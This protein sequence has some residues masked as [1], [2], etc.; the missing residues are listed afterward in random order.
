M[1]HLYELIQ[2]RVA[3][4]R[5][6]GYPAEGYPAIGEILDYA[7]L[8]E[9]RGLRLLRAAQLRALETYW[10]LR[11]VEGTPH[12]FD[13]YQR[14]YT[15][16]LDLLGAL[17]MARDEIKDYVLNEGMEELWEHVRAG[18][19]FVKRHKLES[20]HETVSLDYPSYI[21]ALAMGA[22]K[23]MLIGTIV[24]T[25]F[26]MA[27]E[28]PDGP[29]VQNAL[30][31]APGLTILE[32]LREL[33]EVDYAKILPPRLYKP[34]ETTYKLIFTRDGEKDLPVIRGSR[35]NLVVTN[36]EKIRIQKR[37]RRHHTWTQL[38]YEHRQEQAE[39]EANLRLQAIA[40]LPN[41]GVFSDEAHHTYGREIGKSLKR[42]RQTVDYLHHN[43]DLLCVVNTT[44]TPYYERQP[45][46]DVVIWYGLSEG[47]RDNIL[48]AV[49]GSIYAYDFDPQH[50]DQ[51]VAEVVHDFLQQYGAVTLPNG[52]PARLAMYF[53]QTRDLRELRPVVERTLIE[54]GYPTDIV[55]RNTSNST[56][57][58]IDAFNRL[59]D[60]GS[61]H[62][63]I[64]LVNK[65]TEGWNCPSLFA[66]ALARK[67]RTSQNFV[68]Q[69]STRCLRQVPGN[70]HRARI[71][72]SMDNRGAL[73]RQ[74]QETYGETI[75]DLD[76]TSQNTQ[77]LKVVVRKVKVPPLVVRQTV[78]RV[79]PVE[80]GASG[81]LA[82]T[83]PEVEAGT[84]LVRQIYT[85]AERP[86]Q[87]SVMREVGE[88]EGEAA[89]GGR[90]LYSVATELAAVYRVKAW[91]VYRELR[92]LYSDGG[93]VPEAHLAALA[94]QIED[95][96]RR[97]RVIEEEVEVS[98]ALVR[99]EG[100]TQEERDGQVVYTAEIAYQKG[101]E[102]L[103][104]SWKEMAA[105][106]G[107]EFGFHYDPYCF[108]S[109]PER[110]FYVRMLEA[111]HL[112]EDQVEDIYFTG[113]LTDPQKTDFYVEYKGVDGRWHRYSPDFVIRRR[114]GRCY[115]VEI[116][117]ERERSHLVD[118]ER[119]RKAMAVQK[120]V[121]LNPETLRYEMI[122]TPA[123]SVAY[124]QLGPAIRFIGGE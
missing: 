89:V 10:Y 83:R 14:T 96:T 69:A 82:L 13:L 87:A 47:I 111:I 91:T 103:L 56:E 77:T 28:Y 72:L 115:I 11:L 33:A 15:R 79:V 80:D 22:G 102:H 5:E 20:V 58:E 114:D 108:D 116:K 30:V 46:R 37:V 88:Q 76:R 29:F 55:L 119:G 26:A 27:I 94:A 110:D 50:A 39:A 105:Q 31:F 23:T 17:G 32:S 44:G 92:R 19:G 123:D 109:S 117:A 66:C 35:Y 45:L 71:Y 65:G 70:T 98:L 38:E 16:P 12:I 43:T 3:E 113:A 118:G 59:N 67:L 4:W 2:Q 100:F 81:E 41:L 40:S 63:V 68:L 93:E 106:D 78:K 57:A 62:R 53:P 21:L 51:F 9:G 64:L 60:P 52:A 75:R 104:L 112:N 61:R 121:G 99:P 97:Y 34:F 36:T 48:K 25:E 95:Q 1:P 90:D 7:M 54:M 120:W 42:V 8:P 73:D 74:L 49:D 84:T 85:L 86:S 6:A 24:A 18:G 107:D 122:F 101:R 124:N